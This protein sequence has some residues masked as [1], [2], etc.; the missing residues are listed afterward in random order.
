[1]LSWYIISPM[2]VGCRNFDGVQQ[3][4][5]GMGFGEL[6]VYRKHGKCSGHSGAVTSR[7]ERGR[8]EL[9]LMEERWNPLSC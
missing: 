1:M 5:T 8:E 6:G 2:A 9:I 4:R 7:R 3:Q